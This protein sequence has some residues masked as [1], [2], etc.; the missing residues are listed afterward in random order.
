MASLSSKK[1]ESRKKKEKII[2]G[3]K[4]KNFTLFQALQ[5]DAAGDKLA[6]M[7]TREYSFVVKKTARKSNKRFFKLLTFWH[8]RSFGILYN[9][10]SYTERRY[11]IPINGHKV[12]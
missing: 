12:V 5:G 8:T 6:N 2:K 4:R 9:L 7:H 11:I 1:I 3:H 10:I